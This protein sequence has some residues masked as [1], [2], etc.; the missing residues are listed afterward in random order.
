MSLPASTD[1]IAVT[2]AGIDSIG[3]SMPWLKAELQRRGVSLHPRCTLATYLN[4]TQDFS[5]LA[6]SHPTLRY[7]TAADAQREYLY[8][9]G[10][11][12]LSK[13]LHRGQACGVNVTDR[14]L[15]CLRAGNPVLTEASAQQS[16]ERDAAWEMLLAHL[17]G[18]FA[19]DVELG[20]EPDVLCS[21][22]GER[23]GLAAKICYSGRE[24]ELRK[25]IRRGAEQ[26]QGS[27]ASYGFVVVNLVERIPHARFMEDVAAAR[28]RDVQALVDHVG[29]WMSTFVELLELQ[30]LARSFKECS[31]LA[32]LVF[33][34]PTVLP[35][36]GV[37][38]PYYR[39]HTVG[40][41]ERHE[42]A[43]PF[44]YALNDAAQSVLSW[45]EVPA[46]S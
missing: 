28:F 37:Q 41:G 12:Y 18:P 35:V 25:D 45:R 21:F 43:R 29:T 9:S 11:D 5:Y 46:G 39:I 26:L 8:V 22:Q 7:A 6:T 33:F 14:Q 38:L 2:D 24:D 19:R 16:N 42:R 20:A 34:V 4:R 32:S 10:T 15:R 27:S 40:I 3:R 36:D 1:D 44:E 17:I 23:V 30:R 13:A 31:K